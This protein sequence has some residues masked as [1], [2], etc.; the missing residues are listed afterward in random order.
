[1]GVVI[2]VLW[3]GKGRQSVQTY[4]HSE[5]CERLEVDRQD[6]HR[7]LRGYCCVLSRSFPAVPVGA[8]VLSHTYMMYTV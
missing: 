2:G 8:Y 5:M 4:M 1:M 3:G 7:Q 6:Q